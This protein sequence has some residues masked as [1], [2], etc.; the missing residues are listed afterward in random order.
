MRQ[1]FGAGICPASSESFGII[2]DSRNLSWIIAESFSNLFW[3]RNLPESSE[4]FGIH[5]WFGPCPNHPNHFGI[6]FD[7][8]LDPRSKIPGRSSQGILDPVLVRIIRI[9]LA[10]FLIR[11][12]NQDPRCLGGLLREFWIQCLPESS[13]SFWNHFWFAPGTK[14][15]DS[16]RRPPRH[17][18]SWIWARIKNDSKMIRM[19]RAGP[20][21]KM[22][23]KWFGWF[24][25][26]L[27]KIQ[28][29]CLLARIIPIILESFLIRAWI[30]DPRSKIQD[31]WE[32]LLGN[33]GSWTLARIKNDSKLIRMIR[34]SSVSK[35]RYS[36][37]PT[38]NP[39]LS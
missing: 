11:A 17:L 37:A 34:A 7:S 13:E 15:Q 25:A 8:G 19:I 18:G 28:N 3:F 35:I 1:I 39:K 20:E 36:V 38:I 9:I 16:L 22:I 14:I 24:R 30:Q 21:S 6:I 32:R 4:S 26:P 31:S 27:S 10:S 2:F 33:L 29:N 23:P 12:R 5:F